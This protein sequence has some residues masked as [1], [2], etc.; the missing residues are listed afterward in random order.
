MKGQERALPLTDLQHVEHAGTKMGGFWQI[1]LSRLTVQVA[2]Y[3]ISLPP[4]SP[5]RSNVLLYATP[6]ESYWSGSVPTVTSIEVRVQSMLTGS[7]G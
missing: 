3:P 6:H 4:T 5:P 2:S 1:N 7:E